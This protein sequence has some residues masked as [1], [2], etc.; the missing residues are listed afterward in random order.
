MAA[1]LGASEVVHLPLALQR[2]RCIAVVAVTAHLQAGQP[3]E[4]AELFLQQLCQAEQAQVVLQ[5][6]SHLAMPTSSRLAGRC[7]APQVVSALCH[8]SH[9]LQ[10]LWDRLIRCLQ[11]LPVLLLPSRGGLRNAVCCRLQAAAL[12]PSTAVSWGPNRLSI[13]A[14]LVLPGDWLLAQAQAQALA[15][16]VPSRLPGEASAAAAAIGCK[17]PQ[18]LLLHLLHPQAASKRTAAAA[19]EAAVQPTTLARPQLVVAPLVAAAVALVVWLAE[20][21]ALAQASSLRLHPAA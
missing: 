13:A 4:A 14:L 3:I 2:L 1:A 20:S 5:N 21:L 19:V 16:L 15:Q 10:A 12:L 8:L 9:A 11:P 18:T 6:V 17:P 7:P